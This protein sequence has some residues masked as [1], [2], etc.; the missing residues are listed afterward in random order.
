[1][2]HARRNANAWLAAA[3]ER[4]LT[5]PAGVARVVAEAAAGRRRSLRNLNLSAARQGDPA[6]LLNLRTVIAA[7]LAVA[8]AGL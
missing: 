3:L 1:L 7:E 8:A 4:R 2:F 6:A 5:L